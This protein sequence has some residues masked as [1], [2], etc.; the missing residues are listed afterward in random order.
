MH[1]RTRLFAIS[2][3]ERFGS[4]SLRIFLKYD[5]SEEGTERYLSFIPNLRLEKRVKKR[6]DSAPCLGLLLALA[7][8]LVLTA[9]L[10]F[11]WDRLADVFRE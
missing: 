1:I 6:V 3:A 5:M 10:A 11:F 2:L 7:L 4:T 8:A 9:L